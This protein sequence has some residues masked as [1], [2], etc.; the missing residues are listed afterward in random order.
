MFRD[1]RPRSKLH[2]WT[3]QPNRHGQSTIPIIAG[4]DCR[5][6]AKPA[7]TNEVANRVFSGFSDS[8]RRFKVL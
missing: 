5:P 1:E 8:A 7:Q 6:R 3:S 2:V 4:V